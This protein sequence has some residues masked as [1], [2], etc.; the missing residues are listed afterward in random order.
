[1]RLRNALDDVFDRATKVKVLRILASPG[2]ELTGREIAAQARINHAGCVRTLAH[3]VKVGIVGMRVKGRSY[4]YTLLPGNRLIERALIP[5]FRT[6]R[7]L[8]REAVDYLRARY[9]SRVLSAAVFGSYARAEETY[10]SDL[11]VFFLVR[12]RENVDSI[13]SDLTRAADDFR[14]RFGVSLNPY[15]KTLSI[16]RM[17]AKTG[18]P[19]M[20]Q[21]IKQGRDLFGRP[22]RSALR[23]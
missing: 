17:M 10:T 9:E 11:D 8:F 20:P 23:P 6:E 14:R 2:L 13:L 19:P 22:L 18:R 5:L 7:A 15:I 16:A 1:M 4:L 3:L 21:I 12:D